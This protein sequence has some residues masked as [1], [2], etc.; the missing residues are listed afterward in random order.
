MQFNRQRISVEREERRGSIPLSTRDA[1]SAPGYR[2]I[3]RWT[4]LA[5]A[6]DTSSSSPRHPRTF[7]KTQFARA[8]ANERN[9]KVKL[10]LKKR[11]WVRAKGGLGTK[12]YR[13][14]G[15]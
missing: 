12:R 9:S 15:R 4:I 5:L 7:Q 10:R 13:V 14:R 3:C 1:S 2:E 8:R 11:G 6:S